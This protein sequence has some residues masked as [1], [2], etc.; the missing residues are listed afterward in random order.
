MAAPERIKAALRRRVDRRKFGR[1]R[2]IRKAHELR[3]RGAPLHRNLGFLLTDPEVDNFTYDLCNTDELAAWLGGTFCV[4]GGL[5]A[6]LIEEARSD[7]ALR[8]RLEAAASSRPWSMKP[9][10]QLGRRLGWYAIVR[11][12][13]PRRII[14]TGTH[15][16]LGSL[17]VI[18]ALE[19]NAREHGTDGHLVSLDLDP[20]A[21]WMVGADP[22]FS[23]IVGPITDTLGPALAEPVDLFLHD[24]DHSYEHEYFELSLAA[25]A[26]VPIL[27]SD[28]SHAT[29]ALRDLCAEKGG[30]YSF[31]RERPRNHFYPGGGIGAGIMRRDLG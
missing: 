26:G 13:R 31:F 9:H 28:N 30:A 29:T 18:A 14:E 15:D 22:R 1:V 25:G 16:G 24:S 10:P 23:L 11:L 20:H 19:R 5:A 12:V 6:R 27:L 21:G 2:W 8:S 3:L 4:P 17:T 7:R